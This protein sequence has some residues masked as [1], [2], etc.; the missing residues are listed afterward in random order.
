MDSLDLGYT[1]FGAVYSAVVD[2]VKRI[3]HTADTEAP[4]SENLGCSIDAWG[5]SRYSNGIGGVV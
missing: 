5:I 4:D 3:R 2:N 1:S